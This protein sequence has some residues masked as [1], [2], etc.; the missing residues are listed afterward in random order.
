[1]ECNNCKREVEGDSKFCPFCGNS[2]GKAININKNIFKSK[3]FLTIGVLVVLSIIFLPRILMEKPP[4][5]EQIKN[6]LILELSNHE[7]EKLSKMTVINRSTT[8][9]TDTIT[10]EVVFTGEKVEYIEKYVMAYYKNEKWQFVDIQLYEPST[11]DKYPIVAPTAELLKEESLE[12]LKNNHNKLGI[13]GNFYIEDFDEFKVSKNQEDLD[14]K[15]KEIAFNY[16]LK[17]EAPI[18]S[19]NGDI[20]IKYNFDT[21]YEEWIPCDIIQTDSYKVEYKLLKT[22]NGN[23]E[24]GSF[25]NIKTGEV[26]LKI[27]KIEGEEINC[28]FIWDDNTINKMKGKIQFPYIEIK[29]VQKPSYY[30]K[31]EFMNENGKL[32]GKI[33]TD[34]KE[35][36]S[37][38]FG[39]DVLT[40][41]LTLE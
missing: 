25:F 16:T 8:E 1:M 7:E 12:Y 21:I 40:I 20:Q 14:L 11:W 2:L 41:N 9:S 23:Y 32:K 19:I 26:K 33:Y 36:K 22:W 17:K 35:D 13:E 34:Y 27:T 24:E 30:S 29:D 10:V 38:Y 3:T 4:S 31:C 15:S 39:S 5:E 37:F 6:D 18:F 28:E